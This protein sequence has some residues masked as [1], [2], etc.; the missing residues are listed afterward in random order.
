MNILLTTK[1]NSLNLVIHIHTQSETCYYEPK[2]CLHKGNAY[3]HGLF[4]I[5]GAY[6]TQAK[7]VFSSTKSLLARPVFGIR[8]LIQKKRGK[9]WILSK[10]FVCMEVML[11]VRQVSLAIRV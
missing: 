6:I 8:E 3:V 11:E 10:L 4:L 1:I 5:C 9:V 2:M 7:H